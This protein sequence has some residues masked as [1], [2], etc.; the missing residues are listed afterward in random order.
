MLKMGWDAALKSWLEVQMNLEKT[1]LIQSVSRETLAWRTEGFQRTS[2][3]L[4]ASHETAR[5]EIESFQKAST[6]LHKAL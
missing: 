1:S 2:K 3:S 6:I 5:W 4:S